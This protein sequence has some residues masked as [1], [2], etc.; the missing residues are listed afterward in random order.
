MGARDADASI[1]DVLRA[2]PNNFATARRRSQR[3]FHH[4]ALLGPERP[5][6]AILLNL[7]VGPGVVAL[8]LRQL[9]VGNA[10]GRIVLAHERDGEPH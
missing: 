5:E 10:L 1:L 3:E 7:V 9:D 8:G 4:E 6:G 2:E